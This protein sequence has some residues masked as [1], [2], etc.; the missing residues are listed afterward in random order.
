[1][2]RNRKMSGVAKSGLYGGRGSVS[3][4]RDV[5]RNPYPSF[6]RSSVKAY[7]TVIILINL[8]H[9]RIVGRDGQVSGEISPKYK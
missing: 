8:P 6:L 7:S 4:F 1:M 9:S 3:A 5:L 2:R